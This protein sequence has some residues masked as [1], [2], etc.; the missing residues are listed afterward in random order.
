M[1]YVRGYDELS[2]EIPLVATQSEARP[3]PKKRVYP[4]PFSLYDK[5][6]SGVF[7]TENLH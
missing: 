1:H 5:V 7:Y 2:L 3:E 4:I 6:H